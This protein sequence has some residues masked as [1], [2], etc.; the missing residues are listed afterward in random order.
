[1]TV[2]PSISG[3][4][5]KIAKSTCAAGVTPGEQL[6][7]GRRVC[8]SLDRDRMTNTLT[9]ATNGGSPTVG[10]LGS[11][12]GLS[13]LGG[14]RGATLEFGTLASGS[15]E[16]LPL[17]VT[18]VGLPGTVQVGTAISGLS[19]SVLTTGQNTCL[20]GIAAGHSCTASG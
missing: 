11:V 20:A 10:L 5:Y 6:H 9:V 13:V 7:S 16:V 15:T 2:S 4:S 8:A 17:T 3:P 18:N 19:F 1:M 12:V 14:V